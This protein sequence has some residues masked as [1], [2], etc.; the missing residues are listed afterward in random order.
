MLFNASENRTVFL[1]Y[2]I[3][4]YEIRLAQSISQPW[5]LVEK[6]PKGDVEYPN[7]S[8]ENNISSLHEMYIHVEL[9]EHKFQ[10]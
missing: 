10:I 5:K 7:I 6:S 4:S 8:K 3:G 9:S 1:P 2:K